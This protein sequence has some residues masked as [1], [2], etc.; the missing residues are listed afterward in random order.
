M[1]KKKSK[2]TDVTELSGDD[3]ITYV[4]DKVK[5]EYEEKLRDLPVEIANEFEKVI[6]LNVIDKYWVE[7]MS[8][9][10]HLRE[11]IYLRQ[12]AQDNPLRAYTQEGFDLFDTM[13]QNIDKD[14]TQYLIKAEIRQN[15]E[16]KEVAKNKITNDSDHTAKSN[17]KKVTKIGRNDPCPCGS[18]KK[19][20]Q[21]CGK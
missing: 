17:P 15:I 2:T 20:K 7:Q 4:F 13:L 3:L 1:F 8:T 12:Y 18:G 10:A 5:E 14:V 19:Y 11:G 21:C 16:R 6:C 9:M